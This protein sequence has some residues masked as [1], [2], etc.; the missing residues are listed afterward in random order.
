MNARLFALSI[1][2]LISL[3]AHAIDWPWQEEGDIPYEYCKGFTVASLDQTDL[4][5]LS[6]IDLWLAWN[7]IIRNGPELA[8]A[9]AEQYQSA[10]D[11]VTALMENGE[12]Q[13]IKD[14]AG[15][16]CALGSN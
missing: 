1:A 14:I 8:D 16:D 4:G 2:T 7:E 9:G 15:G 11:Q 10:F 6:R 12:L 5:D 3:P 13:T